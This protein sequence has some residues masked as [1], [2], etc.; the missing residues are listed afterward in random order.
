MLCK[1]QIDNFKTSIINDRISAGNV[2]RQILNDTVLFP[3]WYWYLLIVWSTGTNPYLYLHLNCLRSQKIAIIFIVRCI[4]QKKILIFIWYLFWYFQTEERSCYLFN[5][6][7]PVQKKCLFSHHPGFSVL[8]AQNSILKSASTQE[9]Q[10][11][12]EEDLDQVAVATTTTTRQTTTTTSSPTTTAPTT[13]LPTTT[14]AK[15]KG[16]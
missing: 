7:T 9:E 10:Q 5:C 2:T 6:G 11:Q 14:K 3:I 15:E 8:I 16:K 1:I 13:I 12:H 4:L